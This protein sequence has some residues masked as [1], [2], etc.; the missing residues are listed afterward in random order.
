MNSIGQGVWAITG[1]L[2]V[3]GFAIMLLALLAGWTTF[4]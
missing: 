4:R 2:I 1:C 3:V